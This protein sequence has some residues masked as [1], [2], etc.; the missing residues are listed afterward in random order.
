M[1]RL[2]EAAS[3]L[4]PD[5]EGPVATCH[6]NGRRAPVTDNRIRAS[7]SGLSLSSSAPVLFRSLVDAAAF[8]TRECIEQY[9]ENGIEVRELIAIGGVAKKHP[10]IM[11]TLA[12]VVGYPVTVLDRN[13]CCAF[14][15]AVHAAVSCGL[16]D[17][18]AEAQEAMCPAD[19]VTYDPDPSKAEHYSVR[20]AKYKARVEENQRAAMD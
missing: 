5:L 6:F 11:Q 7:I 4:P 14:G 16:Y 15:S 8:G 19:G 2:C 18:V 3:A 20:Y 1:N 9:V 10:Y 12:D 17:S 13:E